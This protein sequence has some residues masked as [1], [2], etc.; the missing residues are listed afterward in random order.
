[1]DDYC[2]YKC[3]FSGKLKI[4]EN[5]ESIDVYT[6]SKFTSDLVTSDKVNRLE[7]FK[8]D[9]IIQNSVKILHDYCFYHYGFDWNLKK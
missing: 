7:S 8:G 6:F 2:L 5:V 9:L 1:M 4:G 3:D